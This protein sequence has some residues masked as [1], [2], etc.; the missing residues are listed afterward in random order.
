MYDL[1]A[2]KVHFLWVP[3][4]R[5][6]VLAERNHL[7]R[8]AISAGLKHLKRIAAFANK[9]E[10][11]YDL[12]TFRNDALSGSKLLAKQADWSAIEDNRQMPAG[13]FREDTPSWCLTKT[14]LP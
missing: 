9:Q 13:K 11:L 6:A 10:T 3:K 7:S 1:S 14:L 4:L 8:H 12:R 5:F 2:G